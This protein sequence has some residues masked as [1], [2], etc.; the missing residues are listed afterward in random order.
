MTSPTLGTM[1][2]PIRLKNLRARFLPFALL[3]GAALVWAPPQPRGFLWAVP[4]I[5]AGLAIRGWGA[6]HLVK[7]EDLTMSGPYAYVRHPLY[8]GTLS[9]GTG[10]ATLFGGWVSLVLLAL[11]WPWFALDYFPRKDRVECARLAERYGDVFQR[12]AVAVPA[13]WPNLTPYR[14][15]SG[16]ARTWALSRYSENNELGTL[17]AVLVGVALFWLRSDGVVAS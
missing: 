4:L 9:I 3:G 16:A 12:Y 11:L 13:L 15:A 5:A 8:L 1:R 17:I 7:N 14:G 10:F 6:G 2:N